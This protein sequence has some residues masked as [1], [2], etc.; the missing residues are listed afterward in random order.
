M[1]LDATE[2]SGRLENTTNGKETAQDSSEKMNDSDLRIHQLAGGN[3]V[4]LPPLFS[5]DAE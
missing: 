3:L 5:T 4:S 2:T 1:C